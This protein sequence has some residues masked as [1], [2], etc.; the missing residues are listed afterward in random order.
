MPTLSNDNIPISTKERL[1]NWNLEDKGYPQRREQDL[2]TSLHSSPRKVGL[3]DKRRQF[4]RMAQA[5]AIPG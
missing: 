2:A 5:P 1:H 3:A 4:Q